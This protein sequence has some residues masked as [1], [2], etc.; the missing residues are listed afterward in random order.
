MSAISP[1]NPG[2]PVDEDASPPNALPSSWVD[3]PVPP[4]IQSGLEAFRRDLPELIEKH[5]GEFVAYSGNR[6]LGIDRS[7]R[8]LVRLCLSQGLST[9]EF[10]VPGIAPE[11]PDDLDWEEFRDI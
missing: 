1:P 2:H 6:R 7:Q 4:L 9:H 10:V 11:I 3:Q 8:K 5:Q